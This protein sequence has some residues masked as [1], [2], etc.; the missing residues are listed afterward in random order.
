MDVG[1]SIASTRTLPTPLANKTSSIEIGVVSEY[2]TWC[3]SFRQKELAQGSGL[4]FLHPIYQRILGSGQHRQA[5]LKCIADCASMSHCCTCQIAG[6]DQFHNP[7]LV[8]IPAREV[9]VLF[10]T[11]QESLCI[12]HS[13]TRVEIVTRPNEQQYA[14]VQNTLLTPDVARAKR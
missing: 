3:C 12:I 4:V 11:F 1:G 14:I 5:L 2:A 7:S 13:Q 9:I 10:I 6:T 8:E